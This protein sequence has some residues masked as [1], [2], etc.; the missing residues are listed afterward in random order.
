MK[1]DIINECVSYY[2][3]GVYTCSQVIVYACLKN[4]RKIDLDTYLKA[5]AGFRAG[6]ASMKLTCGIIS[7]CVIVYSTILDTKSDE[8]NQKISQINDLILDLEKSNLCDDI[9]NKYD[10]DSNERKSHCSIIIEKVLNFILDDFNVL[11]A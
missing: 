11:Q 3:N 6:M 4:N 9:T 5:S 2:V 10:F 7:G 1:K 8:Y